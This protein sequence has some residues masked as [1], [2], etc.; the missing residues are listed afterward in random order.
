MPFL[1]T[2]PVERSHL[3]LAWHCAQRGRAGAGAQQDCYC[4]AEAKMASS[5]LFAGGEKNGSQSDLGAVLQQ[6]HQHAALVV[7]A[8][9]KHGQ[10]LDFP[11]L[12]AWTKPIDGTIESQVTKAR[13]EIIV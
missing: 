8:T 12:R 6:A 13:K 4:S 7:L 3:G 1:R 10:H 5:L 2:P 11:L 9:K